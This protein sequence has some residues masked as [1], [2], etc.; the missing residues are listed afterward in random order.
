MP[1]WD[2][3]L[4][5]L[6]KCKARLAKKLFVSHKQC[7]CVSDQRW[8]FRSFKKD[9]FQVTDFSSVYQKRQV[10]TLFKKRVMDC[11]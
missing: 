1:G 3:C 6:A 11:V 10:L 9:Y 2:L 4:G 8:C 7:V 5:P